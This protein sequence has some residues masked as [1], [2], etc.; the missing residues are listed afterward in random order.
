ME[1]H[2]AIEWI[3]MRDGTKYIKDMDHAQIVPDGVATW[4]GYFNERVIIRNAPEHKA[5]QAVIDAYKKAIYQT[6]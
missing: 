2:N 1:N 6:K 3:T 5:M 4:T